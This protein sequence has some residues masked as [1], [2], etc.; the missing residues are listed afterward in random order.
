[1]ETIATHK[2]AKDTEEAWEIQDKREGQPHGW[3]QWKGTDVCMDVYCIC[4][5]H[6]HVDGDFYYDLQCPS[7]KRIYCTNGHIEFIELQIDTDDV[8]VCREEHKEEVNIY[9]TFDS[10]R[11]VFEYP[12]KE[13]TDKQIIRLEHTMKRRKMLD[14][15][16][17]VLSEA[18]TDGERAK[19]HEQILNNIDQ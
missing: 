12:L 9:K 14:I 8:K 7:C 5:E 16:I 10:I 1:M 6:S 11:E 15:L 13:L 2:I 19:V 3:I 17:K 4:G 18:L